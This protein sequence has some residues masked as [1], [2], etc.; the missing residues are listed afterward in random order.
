MPIIFQLMPMHVPYNLLKGMKK[1]VFFG[2]VN[3]K[4]L[5]TNRDVIYETWNR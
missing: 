5:P 3:K 2:I 1:S 4:Q